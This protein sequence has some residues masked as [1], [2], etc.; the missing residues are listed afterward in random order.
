VSGSE[1]RSIA[2][3]PSLSVLCAL[4]FL[5]AL[6]IRAPYA[7]IRAA[8][9]S[10]DAAYYLMVADNLYHGRGLV[11]D[12]V[13][14]Y[15][16]GLPTSLPVPSNDYWMP[17]AS[18][19][20]A[21]AFTIAGDTSLRVAQWPPLIFGAL[22]CAITAWIAGAISQRHTAAAL[23][24]LAA[25][26]NYYL[27]ELSIQP[28]HFML[29]AVLVNLSLLA[30]WAA[31]RGS[32]WMALPAGA[33][34]GLAYLTR[35]D[36]ALLPVAAILLVVLTRRRARRYHGIRVVTYF[37]AAMVIVAFPWCVRQALV[38]GHP[39]GAGPL[40]TA[41]LTHYNDLFRL[42]QSQLNL[43]DYLQTNQVV[44]WGLKAYLLGVFL[45]I[46]AKA[47]LL[48][49]ALALAALAVKDL[50][51]ESAPWLIYLVLGLL[52]PPLLVPYPAGK[53]GFWHLMPALIPG[54]L[55]L[56]AV[57]AVRAVETSRARPARMTAA[58]AAAA[59]G[60]GS[61]FYWWIIP[62]PDAGREPKPIYPA[63][64]ADAVRALG[65]NPAPALTDHAWGLYYV[66]RIPCA[67]FPSD[68]AAAALQVADA[69]GARYLITRADAPDAIPAMKEV[70]GH[71][72]FRPL[73]R[74]P[75][76]DTSLLVYRILPA[77]PPPR[78]RP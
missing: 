30:L 5:L 21:L 17:G 37:L 28:D 8:P 35:S 67:Q 53:G 36:A 14:N 63:V 68:G 34:A 13:W 76:G 54:I 48:V 4:V 77:T 57:A 61:L 7:H 62:P 43:G 39:F 40:R 31:W 33:L 27:V 66:A 41:F 45:R 20:T 1:T 6:A 18:A 42:D 25:A 78:Q 2:R 23:A 69:I 70:I 12:Y 9:V 22:L 29:N 74:Y 64:A 47:V 75:A 19:V 46:L 11:S 59:V 49:G 65:P 55:A 38:F 24:G 16:A 52:V 72:R 3:A 26:V 15:L 32:A 58:L 50:R 56:G 73:T 71:P 44:A 10:A 60:F 51:R